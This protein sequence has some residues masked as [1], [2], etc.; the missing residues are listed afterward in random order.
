MRV[1]L[2]VG[3]GG[4]KESWDPGAVV[5]GVQEARV[6]QAVAQHLSAL[7]GSGVTYDPKRRPTATGLALLLHTIA[8]NPPEA[9]VSLHCDSSA[10]DPK[11]HRATVY[12]WLGDHDVKRRHRSVDLAKRMAAEL[13]SHQVASS[14]SIVSAPYAHGTDA[15][16]TPGILRVGKA[17]VLIELG[18]LSD[19]H[20]RA[21]MITPAWQEKAAVAI[22]AAVRDWIVIS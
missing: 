2:E 6:V 20:T 5:D 12:Y 15:E 1:V 18:Y 9:V 7:S 14:V 21:Q 11:I 8:L 17:A 4:S 13:E 22:D 3:H 16:F 19:V 10:T